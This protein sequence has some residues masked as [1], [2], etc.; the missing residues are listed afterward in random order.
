MEVYVVDMVVKSKEKKDHLT[1]LQESFDLLWK[2]NI[3][4]NPGKC[5]VALGK[6]LSYLVTKRGIEANLGQ[7]RAIME[8]KS[9]RT[10]KEIQSNERVAAL[11]R[12]LTRS[13]NKRK[14]FFIE[15]KKN[16]GLL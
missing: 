15:I 14:P 4:L 10:V 5:R 1:H 13:I 12:F 2:Y 7:I 3:K 9:P 6:F 8:M 11:S 16:K